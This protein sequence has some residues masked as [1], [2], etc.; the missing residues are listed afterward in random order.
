[1]DHEWIDGS[2]MD[3]WITSMEPTMEAKTSRMGSPCAIGHRNMAICQ[4]T[5]VF[6]ANKTLM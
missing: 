4:M 3:R 1:M 5:L 2:R 6:G